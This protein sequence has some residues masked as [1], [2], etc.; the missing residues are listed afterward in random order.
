MPEK[1]IR[2]TDRHVRMPWYG[3]VFA[4]AIIWTIV[5]A[6]YFILKYS[7]RPFIVPTGLIDRPGIASLLLFLPLAFLLASIYD[8]FFDRF[9][10]VKDLEKDS[11][12]DKPSEPKSTANQ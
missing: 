1:T 10:S 3:Y 8:Y 5:I 7:P 12:I 6:I 4:N 9:A 11:G 2:E